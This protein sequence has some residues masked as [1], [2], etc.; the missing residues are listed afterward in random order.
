MGARKERERV[1]EL[2]FVARSLKCYLAAYLGEA[3]KLPAHESA[4][5]VEKMVAAFRRNYR[6]HARG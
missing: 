3:D 6:E 1:R 5:R 4:A 2:E